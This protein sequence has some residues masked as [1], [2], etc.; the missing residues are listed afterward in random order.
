MSAGERLIYTS[1]ARLGS[2][3]VIG[4]VLFWLMAFSDASALHLCFLIRILSSL[5]K[6]KEMSCLV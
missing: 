2:C 1:Q 4:I 6:L 5:G 3:V